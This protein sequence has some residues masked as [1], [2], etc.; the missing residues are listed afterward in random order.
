ME[1]VLVRLVALMA[2]GLYIIEVDWAMK[3]RNQQSL[4]HILQLRRHF[5]YLL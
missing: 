2:V 3:I 1:F 4:L 5:Y